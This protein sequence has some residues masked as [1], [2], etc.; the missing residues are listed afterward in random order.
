VLQFLSGVS[1]SGTTVDKANSLLI[2]NGR[3]N[4]VGKLPVQAAPTAPAVIEANHMV[5]TGRAVVRK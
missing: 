4:V 3:T 1:V 5:S 2:V